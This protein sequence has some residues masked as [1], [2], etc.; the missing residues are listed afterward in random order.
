[1]G[2]NSLRS[3]VKEHRSENIGFLVQRI[4]KLIESAF[5]IFLQAQ[6]YELF[7]QQETKTLASGTV[8]F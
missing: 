2:K 4:L 3:G 7:L 6:L 8:P 5:I 1:M